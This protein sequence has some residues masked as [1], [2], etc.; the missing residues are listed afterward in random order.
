VRNALLGAWKLLG[1][2][3][4]Q[5]PGEG[6]G[7]LFSNIPA[8]VATTLQFFSFASPLSRAELAQWGEYGGTAKSR[9]DGRSAKLVL[10][11]EEVVPQNST[12]APAG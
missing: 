6:H 7:L 3:M 12:S 4:L 2:W 5:F 10:R 8:I 9:A 11:A 1:S